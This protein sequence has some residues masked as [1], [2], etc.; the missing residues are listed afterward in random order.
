MTKPQQPELHRSGRGEIDEQSRKVTRE[1]ERRG[2]AGKERP[3][4]PEDNRPGHHPPKEQD[5]PG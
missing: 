4:V 1:R 3:K 2:G 5:K